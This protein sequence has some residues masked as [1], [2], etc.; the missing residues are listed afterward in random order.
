LP[1]HYVVRTA[2]GKRS[3]DRA[4][5]AG[6]EVALLECQFNRR[7][8]KRLNAT[9]YSAAFMYV[10]WGGALSAAL[11][12]FA[13]HSQA[14]LHSQDAMPDLALLLN[15]TG[16]FLTF[17]AVWLLWPE[18]LGE[19]RL[20]RLE[21]TTKRFLMSSV[22][23]ATFVVVYFLVTLLA[24]ALAYKLGLFRFLERI[25]IQYGHTLHIP[26]LAVLILAFGAAHMSREWVSAKVCS[27][28]LN[29]LAEGAVLRRRLADLG[30]A[31]LV[32]GFVLQL[33]ASFL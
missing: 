32:M 8:N 23:A 17:A 27:P 12:G 5:I 15:R 7:S 33:I 19:S 2:S 18:I 16:L 1:L 4:L 26:I 3:K 10:V 31:L 30:I 6:V 20:R 11:G 29:A 28:A 14:T 24:T 25:R 21:E 13:H 9:A 22:P